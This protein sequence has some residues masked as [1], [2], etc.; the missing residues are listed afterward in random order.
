MPKVESKQPTV[1]DRLATVEALIAKENDEFSKRS[2]PFGIVNDRPEDQLIQ[3][4]E[5]GDMRQAL[6]KPE[7][8]RVL[9][10]LLCMGGLLDASSDPNPTIMSHHTGRRSLAV[11]LYDAIKKVDPGAYWQMEREHASNLKSREKQNGSE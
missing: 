6:S 5:E 9:Y 4:G 8:R 1:R 3:D 11:D 7:I 2:D 10:R